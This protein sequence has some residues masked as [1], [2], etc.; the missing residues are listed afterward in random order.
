MSRIEN[1][2]ELIAFTNLKNWLKLATNKKYQ[3]CGMICADK[4][5]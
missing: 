5:I 1:E 3:I 4:M 2:L